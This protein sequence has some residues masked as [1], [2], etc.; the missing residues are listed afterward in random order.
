MSQILRTS[1]IACHVF[2]DVCL[3]AVGFRRRSSVSP[4]DSRSIRMLLTLVKPILLRAWE[5]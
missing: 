3:H 5:R 2:N 4:H 1:E